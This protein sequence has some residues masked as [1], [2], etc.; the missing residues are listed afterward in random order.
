ME[1]IMSKIKLDEE[2]DGAGDELEKPKPVSKKKNGHVLELVSISHVWYKDEDGNM[3]RIPNRW[4][5][6][7]IGDTIFI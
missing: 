3:I 6:I 5:G 7:K 4:K 2:L 1:I